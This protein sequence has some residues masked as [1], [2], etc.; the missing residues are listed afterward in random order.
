MTNSVFS[1]FPTFCMSTFAVHNTVIAQIDK[2][3]K[4]YLWR[5][6]DVNAKQNPKASWTDVCKSKEEGGLGVINLKTKNEALLLKHLIKF[7]NKD[8]IPWVALVW[9]SYYEAGSL[10]SLAKKGSGGKTS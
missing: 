9:E 3:R 7:F 1:A 4:L 8:D 5:G 2:F 10:P 6:A